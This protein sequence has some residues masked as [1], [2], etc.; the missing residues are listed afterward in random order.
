M[1]FDDSLIL[2]IK[3]QTCIRVNSE[4]NTYSNY[5]HTIFGGR[6]KY[7]TRNSVKI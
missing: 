7:G 6:Q 3:L 1:H 5:K 2:K 4:F